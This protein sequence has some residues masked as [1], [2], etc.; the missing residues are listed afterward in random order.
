M[1][2]VLGVVGASWLLPAC[3]DS[4]SGGALTYADEREEMRS[5]DDMDAE[6]AGPAPCSEFFAPGQ[7]TTGA[8]EDGTCQ[9]DDGAIVTPATEVLPCDD[10]RQLIWNEFGW[11]YLEAPWTAH[12]EGAGPEAPEPDRVACDPN[13]NATTTAVPRVAADLPDA[14][15]RNLW[16]VDDVRGE[17]W[18]DR[19]EGIVYLESSACAADVAELQANP[20]AQLADQTWEYRCFENPSPTTTTPGP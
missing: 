14:Q 19:G 17:F 18:V 3:G 8:M 4:G 16:F 20:I 15:G 1:V 2:L 9:G 7:P 5:A 13:P 6:M 12:A 10:G 11:G